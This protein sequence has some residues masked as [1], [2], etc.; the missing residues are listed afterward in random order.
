LCQRHVQQLFIRGEQVALVA[1]LP[2]WHCCCC[3][4]VFFFFSTQ[5]RVL[6]LCKRLQPP[7]GKIINIEKALFFCLPWL[8]HQITNKKKSGLL[9]LL[10]LLLKEIKTSV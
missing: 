10:L 7:K 5:S 1:V 9:L 8:K 2:L 4:F 3:C 6:S